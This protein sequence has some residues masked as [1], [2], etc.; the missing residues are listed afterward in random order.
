MSFRLPES[1]MKYIFITVNSNCPRQCAYRLPS[2]ACWCGNSF[3][4]S[5]RVLCRGGLSAKTL[6]LLMPACMTLVFF[7][8]LSFALRNL[9]NGKPQISI[10]ARRIAYHP[11]SASADWDDIASCRFAWAGKGR[12]PYMEVLRHQEKE[13]M[14]WNISYL[15]CDRRRLHDLFQQ[16]SAAASVGE[17]EQLLKG[18]QAAPPSGRG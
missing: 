17:R 11:L 4:P 1:W 10:N 18:F 12:V 5:G 16:L 8:Y 9:Q 3:Y 7:R 2:S 14:C 6:I 15:A 13:T